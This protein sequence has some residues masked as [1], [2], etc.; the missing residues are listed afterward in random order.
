MSATEPSGAASAPFDEVLAVR[1]G[2]L[3]TRRSALYYR[4]SEYGEPD[5]EERMDYYFWLLRRG[6]QTIV[7]DTGFGAAAGARRGR[8]LLCD[9]GEALARLGVDPAS[10]TELIVTHLHYDHTGNL[11]L[12]PRAQLFVDARELEFW[13][14]PYADRP[15][16]AG[17][18]E[19][20]ELEQV[21][22]ARRAG[23]VTAVGAEQAVVP[24]VTAIRVG[25]HSPGQQI[26][27]VATRA[28]DVVLASDAAHFY[29]ELTHDRPFDVFA[30]LER[31]YAALAL[32]R[33]LQDDGLPVVVGHD[34][35][36]MERF[37]AVS[38]A[39]ADLAVR[40]ERAR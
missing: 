32:L 34:P 27:R 7:V 21:A 37:P 23:R 2:T 12:F 39:L 17:S 29:E 1:Y 6:E 38:P 15:C 22:A 14:G 28:G 13:S 35:A 10:V 11:G 20:D 36:V 40:I 26:L 18:A 33:G 31:S 9:T 19:R 25:G 3:L 24:G 30:D 5:A 4:W 16:F 8:T